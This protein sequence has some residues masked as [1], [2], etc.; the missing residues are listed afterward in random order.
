MI[1]PRLSSFHK[2]GLRQRDP[3]APFLFNIIA[4]ALNGLMREVEK[5]NLFREF[6]VGSN[7]VD[8]SILQYA[9]ATIFFWRG[10]DGEC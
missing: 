8:I 4:E 7:N 6:Q 1:A 3:L 2:K 10:F 5:Q 9:D